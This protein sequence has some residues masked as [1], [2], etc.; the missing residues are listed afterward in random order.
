MIPKGLPARGAGDLQTLTGRT[1]TQLPV[2]KAYLRMSFLEL[3]KARHGQEVR[4]LH[5]R[6]GI[7]AARFREIDAELKAIHA[8][9]DGTAP[10]ARAIEARHLEPVGR[11]PLK[12]TFELSY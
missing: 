9:L 12:R 6:L 11:K 1:D 10:R 4:T 5:L 8:N 7:I 3:E 2:H